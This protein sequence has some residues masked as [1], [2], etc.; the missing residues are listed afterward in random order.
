MCESQHIE[1][2]KVLR[3]S[4]ASSRSQSSDFDAD[5]TI[6]AFLTMTDCIRGRA[7]RLLTCV[8]LAL[9]RRRDTDGFLAVALGLDAVVPEKRRL[10]GRGPVRLHA[11]QN[12]NGRTD[13]KGDEHEVD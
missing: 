8:V 3:S 11:H 12:A 7:R 5:S 6:H 13:G 4:I 10:S 9:G 2:K 1:S